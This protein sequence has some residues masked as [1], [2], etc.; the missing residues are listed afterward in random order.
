MN[1]GPNV[2]EDVLAVVDDQQARRC[3]RRMGQCL[4]TL[5]G[6]QAVEPVERQAEP[7]GERELDVTERLWLLMFQE[8]GGQIKVA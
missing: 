8:V 4:A 2:A 6:A 3:R 7:T 1:N 5:I